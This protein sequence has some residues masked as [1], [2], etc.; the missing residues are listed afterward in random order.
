MPAAVR[1]FFGLELPAPTRESLAIAIAEAGE[2]APQMRPTLTENLHLTLFFVGSIDRTALP[3]LTAG[4]AQVAECTPPFGLLATGAGV[5]GREGD[6]TSPRVLWAGVSGAL[7]AASS[8]AHALAAATGHTLDR[9]W[10]GHV[11]LGRARA[12]AGEPRLINA[13]E[14]LSER[15]FGPVPAQAVTLFESRPG[16][17]GVRY[18]PLASEELLGQH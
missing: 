16:P 8:L 14:A 6:D 10:R 7:E 11:T 3:G 2:I 17:G 12:R 9:P 1:V 4:L 5:F 15:T 18:L 13:R